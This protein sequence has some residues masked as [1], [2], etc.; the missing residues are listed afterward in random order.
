MKR[1]VF[2]VFSGHRISE[3][4]Q[5]SG[6]RHDKL[7][8]LDIGYNRIILFRAAMGHKGVSP[9]SGMGIVTMSFLFCKVLD[10]PIK[11]T[12]PSGVNM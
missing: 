11:R 6:S 8:L 3:G 2:E 5:T 7:P 4:S 9:N 1:N 12:A 10:Y